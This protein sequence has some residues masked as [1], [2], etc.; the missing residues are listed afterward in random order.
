MNALQRH[1]CGSARVTI[2]SLLERLGL[3]G[4]DKAEEI[5]NEV[6]VTL[7]RLRV[8]LLVVS[9][10]VPVCAVGLVVVAWHLV[11]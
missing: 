10:T 11:S 8:L 5:L 1:S 6:P 9:V 3:V 4:A 7:K 2:G